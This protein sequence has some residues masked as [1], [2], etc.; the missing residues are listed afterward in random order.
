MEH[1]VTI[2]KITPTKAMTV[3]FVTNMQTISMDMSACFQD[4]WDYLQSQGGACSGQVF[5]IYHI[6]GTLEA[7]PE[8]F[9]VEC[10]FS[11]DS[12]VPDSGQIVGRE[13]EG[14]LFASV[15]HKGPYN[16]LEA[17][18]GAIMEWAKTSQYELLSGWRDYYIND[19]E[20]IDPEEILTEVVCE[21]REKA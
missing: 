11:V 2:R 6:D 4:I 1:E 3:R 14:G 5:A 12:Y 20:M 15:I 10:G 13:I 9:D 21:I 16:T 19:P 8:N 17:A 7:V 18:Y